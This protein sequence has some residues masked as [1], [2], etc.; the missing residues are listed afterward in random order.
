M[1]S[2]VIPG[3]AGIAHILTHLTA[4]LIDFS[5]SGAL[6]TDVNVLDGATN[7][8]TWHLVTDSA[9]GPPVVSDSDEFDRDITLVGS[10]G[11]AMTVQFSSTHANWLEQLYIT[12][13]DA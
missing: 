4:R 12:G 10:I 7:I 3:A 13:F 9:A 1:A 2:I 11:S 5:G 8:F 6:S